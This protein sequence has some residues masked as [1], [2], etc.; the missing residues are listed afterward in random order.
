ML[1]ADMVEKVVAS[2]VQTRGEKAPMQYRR[3]G[4]TNLALSVVTLGGMRYHEGWDAPRSEL[5]RR[6]I[7]QCRDVVRAAFD[8]GVNHIETAHGY[9]KSEGLYAK[10]LHEELRLR[11]DSYFFMT[12]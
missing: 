9:V 6:S 1:L 10:V 7:E 8:V 12:K 2:A 5:P 3:F 11:R 4:K